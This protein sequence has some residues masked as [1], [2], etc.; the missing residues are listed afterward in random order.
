MAQTLQPVPPHVDNYM[1]TGWLIAKHQWGRP[2]AAA[3][4]LLTATLAPRAH[5]LPVLEQHQS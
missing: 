5:L 4:S 3:F 2:L 1:G